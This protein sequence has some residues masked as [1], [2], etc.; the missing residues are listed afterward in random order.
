MKKKKYWWHASCYDG[1]QLFYTFSNETPELSYFD[2]VNVHGPF[3]YF[4]LCR[5]DAI[6]YHAVDKRNAQR[7]IY[8]I[9]LLKKG[10]VNRYE[11]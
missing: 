10:H 6:D 2:D 1:S 11:E 5:D 3:D 7:N 8:E 9:R 4:T